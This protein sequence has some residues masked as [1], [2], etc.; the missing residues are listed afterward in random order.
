[1]CSDTDPNAIAIPKILYD[2]SVNLMK[3][4]DLFPHGDMIDV[5]QSLGTGQTCE[6]L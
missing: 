2:P 5:L 6:S 4:G 3:I 1:M